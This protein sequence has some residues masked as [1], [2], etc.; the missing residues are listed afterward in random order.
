MAQYKRK[1]VVIDAI[2]WTGDNY[3]EMSVFAYTPGE[4]G[5]GG[6]QMKEDVKYLRLHTTS[7]LVLCA[8][9]DWVIK[10]PSGQFY[11]CKNGPFEKTYEAVD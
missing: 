8:P 4:T 10:N 11:P 5:M 1:P 3:E 9:T 2:Q 6:W 7:G